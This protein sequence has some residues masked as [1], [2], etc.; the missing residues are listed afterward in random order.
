M[1]II[2]HTLADVGVEI[3]VAMPLTPRHSPRYESLPLCDFP[4]TPPLPSKNYAISDRTSLPTTR[5]TKPSHA[6]CTSLLSKI[7]QIQT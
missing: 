1:S 7:S 4:N 3:S 6:T 2:S 5:A